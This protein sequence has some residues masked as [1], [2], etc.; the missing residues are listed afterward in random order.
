V[1]AWL[2]DERFNIVFPILISLCLSGHDLTNE[3]AILAIKKGE[4]KH[5]PQ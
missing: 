2:K 4:Y 5:I 1:P 3:A